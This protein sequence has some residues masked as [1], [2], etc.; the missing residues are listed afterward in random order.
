MSAVAAPAPPETAAPTE[1]EIIATLQQTVSPSRLTLF[2]QCRLKF[3]F[4]YVA[5]GFPV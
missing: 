2:L 1:A 5:H 4:R 3:W